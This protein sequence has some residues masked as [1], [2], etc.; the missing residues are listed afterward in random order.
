MSWHK[1][2]VKVGTENISGMLNANMLQIASVENLGEA[3]TV[4]GKN[5]KIE[6][7]KLKMRVI[8][9]LLNWLLKWLKLILECPK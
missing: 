4:N 8:V 7:W 2:D 5:H 1:V 6:L 9:G 3:I